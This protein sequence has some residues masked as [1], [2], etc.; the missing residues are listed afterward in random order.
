MKLKQIIITTLAVLFSLGLLAQEPITTQS[1]KAKKEYTEASGLFKLRNNVAALESINRAIKEDAAFVEAYLLKAEICHDMGRLTDEID[2][3][4]KAKALH[5][6]IYFKYLD[7]NLALTYLGIGEYEK[8]RRCYNSFLLM[9]GTTK[10]SREYAEENLQK[11]EFALTQIKNPVP[12]EPQSLGADIELPYEQYWPSLSIDAKTLVFTMLL[13]DSTRFL[14]NGEIMMQEDFYVTKYIDGKWQ[15]PVPIGSSINTPGNEGAQQISADGKMLVFTSCNRRDGMGMCDIYFARKDINGQWGRPYNAGSVINT[16]YSEKQPCLSPDGRRLYFASDRPG[17]YGKLDLWVSELQENG[18]WGKPVNLGERINTPQDD[19]SPFI[20]PDNRT[21][22][23]SSDGRLGM[24]GKDIYITRL[25]DNLTWSEPKNLGYPINTY[26]DEIGLVVDN[27]GERAFFSSNFASATKNIYTF[28]LP[29]EVRPQPV[30]YVH[31]T[32]TDKQTQRPLSAT[33]QLL[34]V[35]TGDTVMLV[36]ADRGEFLISLP[37]GQ[38]YAMHVNHADYLF[39]SLHFNLGSQH[40][41]IAPKEVAIQLEK[42]IVG[43]NI[44]LNNI[45]FKTNSAELSNESFAELKRMEQFILANPT[46]KFEIG[47]HTDN[48][49]TAEHNQQLSQQRAASVYKYLTQ[50]G[51]DALRLTYKGY[52]ATIPVADNSTSEGRSQNRRTELKI[53][54]TE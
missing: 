36:N 15:P 34:N 21:L 44:V 13:P 24:G 4:E 10:R 47:G 11:I 30:S 54:A 20:H 43:T 22:Y 23:F 48:I 6:Q 32:I 2:A 49:G 52:G 50:K 40:T 18:R 45:F 53:I 46:L 9:E 27:S 33:V 37:I 12:F 14:P 29:A 19:I 25:T 8:A 41:A 28:T 38:S 26:R 5:G 35:E 42:P 16:K 39:N 1:R 17:G 31:G 7:Y 3:F 51:I